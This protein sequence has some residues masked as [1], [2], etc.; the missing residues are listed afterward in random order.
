M[1]KVLGALALT[2]AA[3]IA[4]PANAASIIPPG[5]ATTLTLNSTAIGALTPLSPTPLGSATAPLPDL[6]FPI[7]GGLSLTSTDIIRHD[8]SGLGL[9]AGDDALNLEDFVINTGSGV[10]TGSVS[11]QIDGSAFDFGS[12]IAL[13]DILIGSTIELAFT[14]EAA[15]AVAFVFGDP[16][17][18]D[19]LDGF[20]AGEA[21][22]APIPVPAA[23]PLMGAALAGLGVTVRR[24]A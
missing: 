1:N 22:V 18:E 4:A 11:G 23:L 2:A 14:D 13:F 8:G 12:G 17:L 6:V 10:L 16:G 9:S 24:R 7:T 19:T 20:V 21:Q 15:E 5:G 3:T